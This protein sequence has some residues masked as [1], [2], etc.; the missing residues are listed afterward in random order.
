MV[1]LGLEPLSLGPNGVK[2]ERKCLHFYGQD[3]AFVSGWVHFLCCSNLEMG[4]GASARPQGD[5]LEGLFQRV[6]ISFRM[7]A[8]NGS[9]R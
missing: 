9:V 4:K 1:I 7:E 6:F 3:C 2:P 5:L 8:P